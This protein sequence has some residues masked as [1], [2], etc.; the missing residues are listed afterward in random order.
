MS[1]V[2]LGFQASKAPKGQPTF[3]NLALPKDGHKHQLEKQLSKA[4]S[5]DGKPVT[6]PD[7]WPVSE[8]QISRPADLSKD[9]TVKIVYPGGE[10]TL[11]ASS[12]VFDFSAKAKDVD[13]TASK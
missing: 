8:I 2:L 3:F 6:V 7:D 12:T 10:K 5:A 4:T 13:I 11:N 1:T 9:G